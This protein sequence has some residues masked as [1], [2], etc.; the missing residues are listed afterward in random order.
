LDLTFPD[1]P[2]GVLP[3]FVRFVYHTSQKFHGVI[4]KLACFLETFLDKVEV[5]IR[6][7]LFIVAV[8]KLAFVF[9]VTLTT[10]PL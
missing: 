8:P 9:G 6:G 1:I 4:I 3:L 5:L 2:V 10:S 7:R